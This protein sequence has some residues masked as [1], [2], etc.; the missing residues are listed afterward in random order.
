MLNLMLCVCGFDVLRQ[1]SRFVNSVENKMEKQ[2]LSA[3][4]FGMFQ[5]RPPLFRVIKSRLL[6]GSTTFAQD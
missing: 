3:I 4:S 5:L 2:V 6:I 1:P